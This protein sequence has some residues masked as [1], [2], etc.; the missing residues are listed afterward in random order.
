MSDPEAGGQPPDP[1]EAWRG[2]RDVYME[3]WA[4]TM[5]QNVN[6]DAY[7][8]ATGAM[9]DAYLTASLPFRQTLEKAMVQALQQ[10]NLPSRNE[11]I[12]LAERLTNIEIRLDDLDAKLDRIEQLVVR[13]APPAAPG[14]SQPS[15]PRE[16][17]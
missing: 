17:Q 14:P 15:E 4:K 9:L 10:L 11:A 6:T 5:V 8:K 7:A 13:S 3:A 12:A 16:G 1:F 2:I